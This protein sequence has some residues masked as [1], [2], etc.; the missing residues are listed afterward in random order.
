M[1]KSEVEWILEAKKL[2][3]WNEERFSEPTLL[4]YLRY[5]KSGKI[6]EIHIEAA[7]SAHYKKLL[8]DMLPEKLTSWTNFGKKELTEYEN[9]FNAA[10][11]EL[12]HKL[13]GEL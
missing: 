7:I 9:G 11:A 3:G 10:I 8:V 12:K 4:E 5:Y 2:M 1:P 13:E 6:G